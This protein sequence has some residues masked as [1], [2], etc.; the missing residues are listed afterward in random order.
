[1]TW[2]ISRDQKLANAR[3]LLHTRSA[4]L[5]NLHPG[6]AAHDGLVKE[7]D[8]IYALITELENATEISPGAI[9]IALAALVVLIL[10][11]LHS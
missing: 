5:A 6:T 2:V 9:L 11:L 4:T 10:T 3:E 8:A 1:M 7:C